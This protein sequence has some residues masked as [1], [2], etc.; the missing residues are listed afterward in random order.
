M[1]TH[2]NMFFFNQCREQKYIPTPGTVRE[3]DWN[4]D[5]APCKNFAWFSA[6]FFPF[7]LEEGGGGGGSRVFVFYKGKEAAKVGQL[8]FHGKLPLMVPSRERTQCKPVCTCN[9]NKEC[10]LHYIIK[11]NASCNKNKETVPWGIFYFGHAVLSTPFSIT[12]KV[13]LDLF[14]STA[15]NV[16]KGCNAVFV[17]KFELTG[18]KPLHNPLSWFVRT[19][20][21]NV[22]IIP[23]ALSLQSK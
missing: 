6:I 17:I 14:L 1:T 16:F 5:N 22:L 18:T 20:A 7:S 4:K 23:P 9:D 15:D 11:L 2:L 10:P 8:L 12:G 21:E 3:R 13:S 19:T